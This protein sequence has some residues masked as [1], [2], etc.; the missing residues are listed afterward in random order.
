MIRL[1][2]RMDKLLVLYAYIYIGEHLVIL[3]KLFCVVSYDIKIMI[4]GCRPTCFTLSGNTLTPS[5]ESISFCQ[6]G[7][8]E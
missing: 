7:M 5:N 2:I 3:S 6:V 4:S 1:R 8:T